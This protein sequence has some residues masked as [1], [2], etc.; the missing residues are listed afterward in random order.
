MGISLGPACLAVL[1]P[2]LLKR[3]AKGLTPIIAKAGAAVGAMALAWS[4]AYAQA[5][6]VHLPLDGSVSNQGSAGAAELVIP[7]GAEQPEFVAG[8][9]G[10]ALAFGKG[11]AVVIPYEFNQSDHPR[12]TVTMWV[13]LDDHKPYERE[14]FSLGPGSG[15]LLTVTGKAGIKIRSSRTAVHER[16]FPV[17]EWVFVA[18]IVDNDA[19]T[20]RIHQNDD[21]FEASGLDIR[22]PHSLSVARPGDAAHRHYIFVGADDFNSAGK[23][24]RNVAVDE[25]RL[26]GEALS[27]K[28][29]SVLRREGATRIADAKAGKTAPSGPSGSDVRT[30]DR[31]GAP[32]ELPKDVRRTEPVADLPSPGQELEAPAP[33]ERTPDQGLS[34]PEG[35]PGQTIKDEIEAATDA[36]PP[37]EAGNEIFCADAPNGDAAFTATSSSFPS[38]FIAALSKAK[39]CDLDLTVATV[40]DK[41]EWIVA[42]SDQI[43]H[44]RD[45]AAPLLSTLAS[46]EK[47]YGGLDAG[48]IS[49]SGAFLLA[50]GD[51]LYGSGLSADTR[52]KAQ[53]AIGAGGIRYFDFHPT[54][55]GQWVMIDKSGA[56]TGRKLP[57]RVIKAIG[58]LSASKRTIQTVRFGAGD[59]WVLM[60]SGSW[61][62]TNGLDSQLVRTLKSF[63]NRSQR[64]DHIAL[65]PQAGRYALYSADKLNG[66]SSDAISNFEQS[67]PISGGSTASIWARMDAHN[68]KGVSIA[69]VEKNRIV[70]ARGYGLMRGDDP[71]SYLFT[72]TTFEAAS[73]SKPIATYGLLQ[74]VEQGKLS[75]TEE[76]VLNALETPLSTNARITLRDN[77]R[78][79]EINLIQLLQHC[80]GLCYKMNGNCLQPG[81]SGGGAEEYPVAGPIPNTADMILGV[82]GA[83]PFHK[84]LSVEAPG[85][86]SMYTSANFLPVQGLI[87]IHGGGFENHMNP[88]LDALNMKAST[89][90]SP[91]PKRS[92]GNHAR[93]WKGASVTPFFAYGEMAGAS[94]VSTP[95][96]IA[97]FVIEVNTSAEYPGKNGILSYDMVQ[98]FLGRD[99]SIYASSDYPVCTNPRAFGLSVNKRSSS[100]AWNNSEIYWHTG[101]HNGYRALMVGIPK[102]SAGI[103]I[104]ASGRK[105]DADAFYTELQAAIMAAYGA[106]YN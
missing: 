49:E 58:D 64:L 28:Q 17:G 24:V 31:S 37:P 11:G 74:L 14:L 81:G 15:L 92:D 7:E 57:K 21:V 63:Q 86:V 90:R 102:K 105:E 42:S 39:A 16:A 29:I 10:Q 67:F 26:Y 62:I 78:T 44:S 48:D 91:Y 55:P 77:I 46:I 66:A 53:S 20:I 100:S 88:I 106:T 80:A 3:Y 85:R 61:V 18:G 9:S 47:N 32:T 73:L 84:V 5:P 82:H 41:G 72:D 76:G 98:K 71:E 97:K 54:D 40:N 79:D 93:G 12:A 43:A 23:E 83:D 56:V 69:Y 34:I 4:P 36:P 99:N 94:I 68:L 8:R 52:A 89:Y 103:V 50:A 75:L 22:T 6:L 33:V 38:D 96:D 45:L 2:A 59:A 19:G 60:G 13:K 30:I 25:V 51:R 1:K 65:A 101:S 70:W 35:L 27:P 87:D 95:T 104:L